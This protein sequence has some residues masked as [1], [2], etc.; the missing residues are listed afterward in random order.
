MG[1]G[2]LGESTLLAWTDVI[3]EARAEKFPLLLSGFP[4]PGRSAFRVGQSLMELCSFL[5]EAGLTALSPEIVAAA[6]SQEERWRELRLL[7]ERYLNCLTRAGLEDPNSARVKAAKSGLRRTIFARDHRGVPD[8]N[9][10][11]QEYLQQLELSGMPVAVLVDAPDCESA[12]FDS[13]GRPNPRVGRKERFLCDWRI[14][15]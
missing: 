8:L 15:W 12:L 13:W 6:P 7:Y 3:S 11:S 2:W 14:S 10:V 9:R 5:A 4:D 1:R